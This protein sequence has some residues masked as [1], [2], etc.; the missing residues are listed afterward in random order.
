MIGTTIASA[1]E[2]IYKVRRSVA[3]E[4]SEQRGSYY[5]VTWAGDETRH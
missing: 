5:K 3:D 1:L 4:G 2:K